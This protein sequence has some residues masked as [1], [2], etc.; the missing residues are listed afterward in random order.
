MIRKIGILLGS[1]TLAISANAQ[2]R[3]L[4][5]DVESLNANSRVNVIIKWVK[6]PDSTVDA[7]VRRRGGRIRSR[8]NAFKSGGYE[9]SVK[10]LREL[11]ND[12][13]VLHISLDH[14]VRA[15][16]DNTAGAMNAAA[17]WT[18]GFVGTGV[19][20][21]VFDSGMDQS[22]DLA[23][24]RIVHTEDFVD[25]NSQP[26]GHDLFGHGQH[27]AGIIGASGAVSSCPN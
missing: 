1:L 17:A 9:V 16:L 22:A 7:K 3:K 13:N 6:Q 26:Y 11:A 27:V 4:S 19:G 5:A 18:S 12:P 24:S 10:D 15:R 8:F 25:T 2:H 14:P 21:A 20:V 23:A